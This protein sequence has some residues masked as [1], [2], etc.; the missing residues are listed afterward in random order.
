M[1]PL[2]LIKEKRR[3]RKVYRSWSLMQHIRC[4]TEQGSF[5]SGFS[6]FSKCASCVCI[7]SF[8]TIPWLPASW[9]AAGKE[10]YGL[11]SI[12][13]SRG[14]ALNDCVSSHLCP[15]FNYSGLNNRN[16]FIFHLY[17][18]DGFIDVRPTNRV[19]AARHPTM[20]H[21]QMRLKRLR[22]FEN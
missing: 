5:L 21:L 7:F 2:L 16:Q 4:N 8:C 9:S 11:L 22:Y 6:D 1:R 10:C 12:G 15:Q 18:Q 14:L 19:T 3:E 17:Q 20:N 13:T